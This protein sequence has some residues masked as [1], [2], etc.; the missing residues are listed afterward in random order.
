MVGNVYKLLEG[1]EARSVIMAAINGPGWISSA[2]ERTSYPARIKHKDNP[3]YTTTKYMS[4]MHQ[5]RVQIFLSQDCLGFTKSGKCQKICLN[6][7]TFRKYSFRNTLSENTL[8]EYR[9]SE[10]TL[11]EYRLS[12]NMFS[13]NML[14]E[15]NLSENTRLPKAKTVTT[16]V[17]QQFSLIA[18]KNRGTFPGWP[19][20]H[21]IG[22]K[23][24][25]KCSFLKI[26]QWTE[27]SIWDSVF[28]H[29]DLLN[30]CL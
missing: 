30:F 19:P 16:A 2:G 4:K 14:S 6:K 20:T 13:Q 12:E 23:L 29:T 24:R 21:K 18:D 17:S 26:S 9:L 8:S 1:R 7:Y 25:G 22:E 28:A 3:T 10:N 11:S 5:E 27:F 15:N